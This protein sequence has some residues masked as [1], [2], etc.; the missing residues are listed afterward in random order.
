[1][2]RDASRVRAR[3]LRD[4]EP[5]FE[6]VEDALSFALLRAMEAW[7]FDGVPTNTS[8]WLERVARNRLRDAR[9]RQSIRRPSA[10]TPDMLESSAPDASTAAS[11][12]QLLA[13]CCD[14]SLPPR[15]QLCS[16]LRW[17]CSFSTVEIAALLLEPVST[18]KQRLTRA[19]RTL[20][21]RGEPDWLDRVVIHDR[22]AAVQAVIFVMF[23]E[24]YESVLQP[25]IVRPELCQSAMDASTALLASPTTAQPSSWALAA[26]VHLQAGRIPARVDA[27]GN[28]VLLPDQQASRYDAPL[29][30]RGLTYLARCGQGAPT[31]YHALAGI[32]AEH[33]AAQTFDQTRW[34]SIGELYDLLLSLD[35]TPVHRLGR[36]IARMY[37]GDIIRAQRELEALRETLHGYAWFHAALARL[38]Q[39]VGQHGLARASLREAV[40]CAPGPRLKTALQRQQS[41]LESGA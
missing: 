25:D 39:R 7:P 26:F 29:I 18:V 32:A 6:G 41:E 4:G 31:R 14:P 20:R 27:A 38:Y 23:S 12:L 9:R 17:A 5:W 35:D 34:S 1:M 28:L 8:A 2:R 13:A 40:A 22:L 21:A 36:S 10:L 33:V 37:E 3:L 19:K 11:E 24:G 15:A 30:R 16:A